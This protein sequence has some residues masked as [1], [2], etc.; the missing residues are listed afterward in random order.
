MI[1]RQNIVGLVLAG[2]NITAAG[3]KKL[4]N[5]KKPQ[6]M[7]YRVFTGKLNQTMGKSVPKTSRNHGKWPLLAYNTLQFSLILPIS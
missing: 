6:N 2:D 5:F 4:K 3:P 1:Q 7:T